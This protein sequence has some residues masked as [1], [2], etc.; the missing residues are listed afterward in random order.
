MAEATWGI[1]ESHVVQVG[2]GGRNTYMSETTFEPE[3]RQIIDFRYS[4]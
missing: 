2:A 1:F 3:N 4:K